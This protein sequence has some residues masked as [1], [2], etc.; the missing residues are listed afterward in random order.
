MQT[1][2]KFVEVIPEPRARVGIVVS[3]FNTSTTGALLKSALRALS[4]RKVMTH[5]DIIYTP[6]AVEIP[7]ALQQ[8][9]RSKKYTALVALGCVIRGDTPHF[10]YVCKIVQEGVLRVSLDYNIPIGFGVLTL[11]KMAQARSRLGLGEEAVAAALELARIKV[12]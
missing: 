12:T 10:E 8:L 4:A 3:R 11:E 2:D 6:G 9:A 5:P 7:Y 1:K